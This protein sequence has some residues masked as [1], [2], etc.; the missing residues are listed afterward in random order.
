MSVISLRRSLSL[1]HLDSRQDSGVGYSGGGSCNGIDQMIYYEEYQQHYHNPGNCLQHP[2]IPFGNGLAAD[3]RQLLTLRQHYYPEGG[4]GWVI[5]TVGVFIQTI[6]HGL[7][8]SCGVLTYAI[9]R[10][11]KENHVNAGKLW[12]LLSFYKSSSV[13]Y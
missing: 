12:F 2:D 13:I 7:Q 6:S 8:L 3:L 10:Q 9:M 4:W 5:T 1:P 11:Y